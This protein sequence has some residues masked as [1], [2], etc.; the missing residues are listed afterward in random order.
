MEEILVAGGGPA[1]ASAAI[2]GRLE[3][4]SVRLM[5]RTKT[6]RHKVCGEF[7]SPEASEI[8]KALQVWDDFR[9]LG[10]QRIRRCILHLGSRVER[11]R[12]PECAWGLS[13][14]QL[15]RLLL[16]KAGA[17]GVIV[18]RGESFDG[19]MTSPFNGRVIYACGR[20]QTAR[21]SD[22]LFGF[23]THFEGPSDDAVELFF[24]AHGYVGVGGIENG[25]TNV[26]GLAPE[27]LLRTY[28]FDFDEMVLRSQPL[29]ERLGPLRRSM[30][31]IVTGP[32]SF[33][34]PSNRGFSA[35]I[36]PAGDSVGF[37]DPF[38]GSGILNAILTGRLAGLAAARRISTSEYIKS[39][40]SLLRRPFFI[41]S[42]L[43]RLAGHTELHWLAPCLPCQALFRL[44]RTS[45]AGDLGNRIL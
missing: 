34:A 9:M 20:R 5:D 32:L 3:G 27:S 8:L 37:V 12:L 7:I 24:D 26:C 38:T 30:R 14:L 45:L 39:C 35:N 13:R 33:A 18:S 19:R 6:F 31:W 40:R 29:A 17:L 10:P 11:W 2:A 1:G 42:I 21:R 16:E 41:S 44:T 15:D 4:C 25:L 23:K 28:A 36:Y 22:R 43:R